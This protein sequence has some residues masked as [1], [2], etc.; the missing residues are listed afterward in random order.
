M[1]EWKFH[2]EVIPLT[3]V[4]EC[5]SEKGSALHELVETLMDQHVNVSLATSGSLSVT[6]AIPRTHVSEAIQAVHAKFMQP[7]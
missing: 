4:G 1:G 6:V 3:V 2:D 7:A 5:M